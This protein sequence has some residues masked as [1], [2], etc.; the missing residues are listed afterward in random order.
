MKKMGSEKDYAGR[1]TMA[2]KVAH[3]ITTMLPFVRNT[4]RILMQEPTAIPADR[5]FQQ[6]SYLLGIKI[7]P[8]DPLY[9]RYY[10]IQDK[11]RQRT[12]DL[13]RLGIM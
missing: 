8:V 5:W 12:A 9:Q 1:Y 10:N 7:K 2:P 13:K 4:S 3:A 6:I 11:I